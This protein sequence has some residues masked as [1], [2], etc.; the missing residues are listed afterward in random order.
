MSRRRKITAMI[1]ALALVISN[2]GVYADYSKA[3]SLPVTADDASPVRE[4][5]EQGAAKTPDTKKNAKQLQFGK[6]TQGRLVTGDD[7]Q[8]YQM[9]LKS[10]GQ[11]EVRLEGDTGKLATCLTDQNGKNWVPRK[12]LANGK[13]IYQ[14]N[15]GVYYY[16][17]QM[18]KNAKIPG[19]GLNYGVT[20]IFKSAKAK[21]EDNN[22]RKKAAKVP[23][24]REFYGHLAQNAAT[25]YYTFTLNELNYFTFS[26]TT[27]ITDYDPE[28]FVV[29]L[30]NKD[31]KYISSWKNPDFVEYNEEYG[32]VY[33]YANGDWWWDAEYGDYI[34]FSGILPAGTYYLGVSVETDKNGKVPATARYGRFAALMHTYMPSVSVKLSHKQAQYTGKKIKAPKVTIKKDSKYAYLEKN[35]DRPTYKIKSMTAG[36]KGGS[37]KDI[38]KYKIVQ[39]VWYNHPETGNDAYSYAIFTVTPVGGKV[40]RVSSKKPGEA[41]VSVKKD[42]QSSGY[43]IQIAR[44]RKFKKSKRTI[45]TKNLRA[46]IKGLS[47]G[48]KYYV[49]VRNYK[50]VK[51]Y[52]LETA[53][54]ENIYGKWSK[55]RTV[56]CK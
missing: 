4:V 3:A 5:T 43:Q 17:I 56:V 32:D 20:A 19:A 29:T 22:T 30:Y 34:G 41:Q 9:T 47:P 37:L 33:S 1:C 42:A 44:D 53:I 24:G 21:F 11:L 46:T 36:V 55:T 51:T 14:L 48:K 40:R 23:L 10:S 54:P 52:Y 7:G 26:L 49:R 13:Q 8:Q 2:V 28:T 35:D 38:G 39:N 16:G 31:G 15:K 45:N 27:Q 18:A 50:E 12:K 6:K 25:E